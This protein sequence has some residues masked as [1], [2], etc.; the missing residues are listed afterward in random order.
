MFSSSRYHPFPAQIAA[1]LLFTGL[2]ISLSSCA[3]RPG[4]P[5]TIRIGTPPLESSALLYVAEDQG[6]FARNGLAVTTRQYDTGLASLEGLIRGE[7]DMGTPAEYALVGKAFAREK[8]SAIAS[9]DKVQYFYLIGRKDRGIASVADL[10]GKRIGVVRKTTAE[11]Y[12]GRYLQ[13]NGVGIDQVAMIDLNVTRSADAIANGEVDAVI[14]RPPY[15]SI[16]EQRLGANGVTWPAQSSQ[17]L[18]AIIVARNDWLTRHPEAVT[19]LLKS[20]AMAEQYVLANPNPSMAIVR[21]R[22]G[23]DDTY[24]RN[25]WTQNQFALQLEQSLI[26]AMEDQARWMIGN[27]LTTAET[28]PNFLDFIDERGLKTV[29]PQAVETIR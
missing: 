24:I 13:L 7:V 16:I 18:Y 25:V 12:L 5:T 6:F 15:A 21:Q 20:L 26:L 23:V 11:F 27:G 8:V 28:V 9:I 10:R 14:S 17:P 29:K 22:L 3:G 4:E 2:S 19:S 1:L